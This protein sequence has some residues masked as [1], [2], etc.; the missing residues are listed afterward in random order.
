VLYLL[1]IFCCDA[2]VPSLLA[3]D[4]FHYFRWNLY[5]LSDSCGS[6]QHIEV[7]LRSLPK[8]CG[9]RCLIAIAIAVNLAVYRFYSVLIPKIIEHVTGSPLGVLLRVS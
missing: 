6:V 7:R 5:Y 4:E 2:L 3:V 1:M 8:R 9:G